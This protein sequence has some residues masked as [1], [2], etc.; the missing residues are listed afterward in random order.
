MTKTLGESLPLSEES[1]INADYEDTE[2][3]ATLQGMTYFCYIAY[4]MEEIKILYSLPRM[5]KFHYSR[6]IYVCLC[7]RYQALKI[8]EHLNCFQCLFLSMAH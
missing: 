2:I 4:Y 3:S 5:L 7:N 8:L 6:T 1:W